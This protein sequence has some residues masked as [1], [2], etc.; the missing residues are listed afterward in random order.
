MSRHHR[1]MRAF[2]AALSLPFVAAAFAHLM[3]PAPEAKAGAS[4][5]ARIILAQAMPHAA[6]GARTYKI[7]NLV[8]E[9]PWTRA[10]PGGA[11]VAGGYMKI[12]NSGKEPDRLVGGSFVRSGRFEVHEMSL[13]GDIMKM[14]PLARGLEIAPGAA[15]ELKPGGFHIMFMDL[16]E[17]LKEG[18]TV[19]G[20][21]VFE[22]A[23]ALAL[24][25]RVGPIGGGAPSGGHMGH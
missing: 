10:T 16:K 22:K 7:G 21:L 4:A 2:S 11:K 25:Y 13:E 19:A 5:N 14:R 17:G 24:E 9:A 8:I 1:A 18:E 12:A 20:T 23:G 6:A 15:V 3:L